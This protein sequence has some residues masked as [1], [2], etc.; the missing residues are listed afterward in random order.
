MVSHSCKKNLW[1]YVRPQMFFGPHFNHW[2]Q[3]SSQFA[4][5]WWW[6]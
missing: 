2:T 6:R 3:L 5:L 1:Q 4:G